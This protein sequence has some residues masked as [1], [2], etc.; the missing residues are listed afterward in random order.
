MC[1]IKYYS[2]NNKWYTWLIGSYNV[3][4]FFLNLILYVGFPSVTVTPTN[5]SVEV[6]LT[7]KFT[8]IVTGA[9]PFTYQ[10]QKGNEILRGETSSTY[11]VYNASQKDQNYYSCSIY[12]VYGDPAVSNRVW[13]QVT[14]ILCF[15]I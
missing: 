6:T 14:S 13:L 2:I 12:N 3:Y 5:Q 9:G 1:I 10:W 8:A 4:N 7:A 11:T 15:N